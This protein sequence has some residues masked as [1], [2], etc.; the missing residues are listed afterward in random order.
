MIMAGK[1]TG[2]WLEKRVQLNTITKIIVLNIILI[3]SCSEISGVQ[4]FKQ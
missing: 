1:K 3:I 2:C 4:P